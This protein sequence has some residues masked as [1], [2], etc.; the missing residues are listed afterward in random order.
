MTSVRILYALTPFS[1]PSGGIRVLFEH[2]S[3][4]RAAGF[5]AYVF[6]PEFS[7]IPM[8]FISDAPV[9]LGTGHDLRRSDI[10]VRPETSHADGIAKIGNRLRQVL[11]VQNQFYLRHSLG[12]HPNFS[13]LGIERVICAS[14]GIQR[15][16]AEYLFF[17]NASFIPCVVSNH[18]GAPVTKNLAVAFMPRKRREE[19]S[20]I[21][22]LVGLMR[23]DLARVPWIKI[24]AV[25][26]ERGLEILAECSVFLSLQRFEGLGLPALEAMAAGCLVAGF[27]GV[28]LSDY[29]QHDNGWWAPDDDIEAAARA[30]CAALTTARDQTPVANARIAVGRAI[31]DRY[32]AAERD[33][34]LLDFFTDMV[35]TPDL[36]KTPR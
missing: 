20:I 21:R 29:A 5:D 15:F 14:R 33:A 32:S 16:L 23:P 9:L 8:H 12:T 24:D 6:A 27:P 19:A 28:A 11:F 36:P 4:L 31:A 2:V 13:K 17:P 34:A 1:G 26:H 30:V 22:H 25:S 7:D 3:V 35:H 18:S 10:I